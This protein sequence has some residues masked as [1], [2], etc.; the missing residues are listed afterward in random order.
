MFIYITAIYWLIKPFSADAQAAFGL[1][2]RIMQT[3]FLSAMAI[4]FA[5][6]TI[7]GQK[8]GVQNYQRVRETFT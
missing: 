5:V 8:F 3:L 7:A 1:G 2:S 6:P 4:T